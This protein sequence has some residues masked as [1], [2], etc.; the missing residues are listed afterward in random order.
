MEDLP[1]DRIM[2]FFESADADWIILRV[3][4]FHY[5]IFKT[6]ILDLLDILEIEIPSWF[7]ALLNRAQKSEYRPIPNAPVPCALPS[8]SG[9]INAIPW[10]IDDN[11]AYPIFGGYQW[12]GFALNPGGEPLIQQIPYSALL[13]NFTFLGLNF[14]AQSGMLNGALCLV[15]QAT[16]YYRRVP[17]PRMLYPGLSLEGLSEAYGIPFG[18]LYYDP[19]MRLSEICGDDELKARQHIEY[20]GEGYYFVDNLWF[21]DCPSP[22]EVPLGH[23]LY[24]EADMKGSFQTFRAK[25]HTIRGALIDRWEY[26]DSIDT[27][28]GFV[29]A[30]P[31]DE[32]C[33][34]V[35]LEKISG[36]VPGLTELRKIAG[37]PCQSG[38]FLPISYPYN[39]IVLME[40]TEP[41]ERPKI[42]VSLPHILLAAMALEKKLKNLKTSGGSNERLLLI[43]GDP[44]KIG[45]ESI[46]L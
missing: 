44:L 33:L 4:L 14:W 22:P 18:S 3:V 25:N 28:P 20:Q 15:S 5:T 38:L 31:E 30:F 2:I 10:K 13:C 7:E 42:A 9:L 35:G 12:G 11:N 24:P 21:T 16:L 26:P 40:E 29:G 19:A 41:E 36:G 27:V 8:L 32:W 37:A 23:V 39:G 1:E 6:D 17:L 46:A 45:G 43:Q 34:S